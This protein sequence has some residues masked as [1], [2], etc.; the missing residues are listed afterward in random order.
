MKG[1]RNKFFLTGLVFLCAAVMSRAQEKNAIGTLDGLRTKISAYLDQPRFS[2]ALWGIKIVSVGSGETLFES[3]PDRLMSP[4]S[5]SKLYTGALG[6]E[7]L[8]GDYRF[9]TPLYT[10]GKISDSGTL[11]GNLV[12]VGHGDPSWNERRL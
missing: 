12:I 6:L 1:L 11:Y 7:Q 4:A 8:G 5:N 10:D 2:G 3:H 9:T